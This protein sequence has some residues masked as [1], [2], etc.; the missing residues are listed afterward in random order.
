MSGVSRGLGA[1]QQALIGAGIIVDASANQGKLQMS[2]ERRCCGK[3]L[4]F[5]GNLN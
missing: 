5:V 2:Q 4:V 1:N 3:R